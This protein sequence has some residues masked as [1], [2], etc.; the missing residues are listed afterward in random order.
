MQIPVYEE[1]TSSFPERNWQGR[2]FTAMELSGGKRWQFKKERG[3]EKYAKVRCHS[4]A[5]ASP[6]NSKQAFLKQ[7]QE[8]E[9]KDKV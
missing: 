9:H 3:V 6:R 2:N 5:C 4:R 1:R 7:G 8:P